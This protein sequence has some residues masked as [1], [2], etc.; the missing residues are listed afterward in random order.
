LKVVVAND[1]IFWIS[2]LDYVKE[3]TSTTVGYIYPD[4]VYSSFRF[5]EI[6]K[7]EAHTVRLAKGTL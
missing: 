5:D 7:N 4:Y 6:P 2:A 1:G 3:F